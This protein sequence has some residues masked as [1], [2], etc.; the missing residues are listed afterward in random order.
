MEPAHPWK[1]RLSV[2]LIMLALAFFGMVVTQIE[3]L[4]GWDYWKWMVP[5]YAILALWLSW[6][7]KRKQQTVSPIT[8]W[9]EVLHWL[10][11]IGTIFLVSDLVHLGTI[12]RFIAGLFHLILISL[13]VFLAGIY[14][15]SIFLLIGI[16]LGIFAFLTAMLVQYMYAF[17]IPV[18]VAGVIVLALSVW[19]SHRNFNQNE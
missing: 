10:G 1:A 9:H 17:L 13:A 3:A 6:Y 16:V 5:V 18:A 12:S 15:E 14:I 19:I 4:G 7:V 11:L 2:G 8:I